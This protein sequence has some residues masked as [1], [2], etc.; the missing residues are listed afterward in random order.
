MGHKYFW[1]PFD[2]VN[3]FFLGG[4]SHF[5]SEYNC[6]HTPRSMCLQGGLKNVIPPQFDNF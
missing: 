3:N 5:F 4:V 6:R 1:H 2:S